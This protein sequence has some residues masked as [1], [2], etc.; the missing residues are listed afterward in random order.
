MNPALSIILFTTLSGAGFGAL[1]VAAIASRYLGETGFWL[2]FGIGFVMAG[3]GLF[4]SLGHLRSPARARF[5]L[6]QWRTSWL[7]REGVLAILTMGLAAVAALVLLAGDAT[8]YERTELVAWIETPWLTLAAAILFGLAFATVRA[9]GMIYQS[10]KAVPA[11]SGQ[12]TALMFILFALAGGSLI[13]LAAAG[14]ALNMGYGL[15]LFFLF[16]LWYFKIVIW[17]RIDSAAPAATVASATGLDG[18]DIRLFERPH[19][20]ENWLTHEMGYRVARRHAMV[21]RGAAVLLGGVLPGAIVGGV[22]AGLPHG[23][24]WI[25]AALHFAGVVLERWLFFAEAK[26]VQSLYYGETAV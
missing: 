24:C 9:T 10:L 16:V 13:A 18:E 21:L 6:S 22:L 2:C 20:T 12:P 7:S 25:A 11:W 1:A 14:P 8:P 15:A 5:A 26:H 23:L 19:V 17:G 4:C 3:A